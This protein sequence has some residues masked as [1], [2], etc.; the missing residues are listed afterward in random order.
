[1]TLSK[2]LQTDALS[3]ILLVVVALFFLHKINAARAQSL[4]A[5]NSRVG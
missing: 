2:D 4:A 5:D 3:A 1:M